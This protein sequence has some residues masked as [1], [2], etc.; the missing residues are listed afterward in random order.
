M[1]SFVAG[2]MFTFSTLALIGSGFSVY[3]VSKL[4]SSVETQ[5]N[6]LETLSQRNLA[7]QQTP[8]SPATSNTADSLTTANLT[9]DQEVE[10]TPPQAKVTS[11]K[12]V[13][14][15]PGQFVNQGFDNKL[16]VEIESTKRIQNPDT[17]DKDIVVVNFRMLR[18][19]PKIKS[20]ALYWFQAKGRNPDTSEEYHT[21]K[22]SDTT[23]LE[24]LPNNAWANAYIWLKVPQGVEAIDIS[25]PETAMFR[26]VPIGE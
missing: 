22:R 2:I 18:L 15:K 4:Q 1:N 10:P 6:R 23:Y 16:K 20:T 12:K 9:Q 21:K 8:V 26:N 5:V 13:A 19:V 24:N 3:Q 14:I 7:N 25:V 17:E 11:E